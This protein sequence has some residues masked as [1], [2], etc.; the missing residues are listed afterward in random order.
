MSADKPKPKP[1]TLGQQIKDAKKDWA[2]LTKEKQ[3]VLR[4]VVLEGSSD[5]RLKRCASDRDGDCV[6]AE[7]PQLRDGQPKKSGRHCPL[8]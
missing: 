2:K 3:L 7:C 4:G 5:L 1:S 8:D 6:H